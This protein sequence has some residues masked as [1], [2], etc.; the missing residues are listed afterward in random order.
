MGRVMR[1]ETVNGAA[2]LSLS[3]LATGGQ[4]LSSALLIPSLAEQS[5]SDMLF[6]SALPRHCE[7][8]NPDENIHWKMKGRM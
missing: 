6:V 2:S 4:E 3:P 5:L 1:G 8:T 7:R